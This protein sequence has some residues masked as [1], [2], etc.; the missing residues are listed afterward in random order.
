[1][2]L[3][4]IQTSLV[5][6]SR[7]YPVVTVTGPRQSG[8]TT[9]CRAT[10]PERAY[11][12]LEA[13]DTRAFA[14]EDPR[15]FLATIPDGAILDEIQRVPD[16]PSYIQGIVDS[17]SFQGKF[18]LTGSQQ[19]ELMSQVS[20]SLAGRTALLRLL[21]LSINEL[22]NA[23]RLPSLF[24][25]MH[26]GFYPRIFQDVLDPT[27]MLSGYFSTYVERDLRQIS[28]IHDLQKFERFVRLC[29]GRTGQLLNM[30]NLAND[31]G[32]AHSTA[33]QWIDLLQA[34]Y[35]IFL[36]PPWFTNTRKRLVK[37][38]KLYFYDV[39]LASWLLGIHQP[40]QIQRDPLFGA[41][42]ENM[43]VIDRLKSRHNAA[44]PV[45]CYF[46]RDNVG[47]EVDLIE[48][49]GS[50][51]HAIEIKAGATINSDYFKALGRFKKAFPE[52]FMDGTVIYGGKQ[53]Q[54]RSDWTIWPWDNAGNF[55][56]L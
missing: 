26:S 44:R 18:I 15:G 12:N 29:A 23:G 1:M 11:I 5:Q 54:K 42:F 22:K 32:I 56:A 36:L 48:P 7:E 20:Q 25:I 34:S 39:G 4:D 38:P 30:N 37:S 33:R 13:P 3:R 50:T 46:Y 41:L 28:V 45:E 55:T 53:S 31:T 10:F 6:A 19:F 24:S 17:D 27:Q 51:V 52:R 35:I 9:L 43:I 40:D 8:K 2:I 47:N 21:P 14:Q 49:H 16:L